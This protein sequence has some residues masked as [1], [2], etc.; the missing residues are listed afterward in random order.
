MNTEKSKIGPKSDDWIKTAFLY[1]GGGYGYVM[2]NLQHDTSIKMA[3]TI[4]NE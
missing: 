1:N 3:V 4:S 2:C